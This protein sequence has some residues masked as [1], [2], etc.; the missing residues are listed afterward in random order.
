MKIEQ[1]R[2]FSLDFPA[3]STAVV[4]N[5]SAVKHFGF[6]DP[7]GAKI[8]TFAFEAGAFEAK[9]HA[10]L[11]VIG[12]VKD[13]NFESLKEN[14]TPLCLRLG[15]SNWS[16]P[17]QFQPG[18][19]DQVIMH[20]ER[21]WKAFNPNTPFEYSFL[22]D[23]FGNMYASEKRLGSIFGIFSTLT[24]VIAC[25]GLFAL[26]AFSAEQRT[27]EI[28]VRKVLG[29]S[30]ASIVYLLSREFGKLILIAFV[31][32]APLSWYAVDWWLKDYAYKIEVG[33]F[34]Y[35]SA[36]LFAFLVAGL[37]MSYQSIKAAIVNPVKSLRAE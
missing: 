23:A 30:V 37:T 10:T 5:E 31:I 12:V 28:G 19:T 6:T 25:L 27:K 9:K 29:A 24:I 15:K 1:G 26:T 7:I 3:D 36:G 18:N 21:T 20:L 8:E 2:N 14:I 16:M 22:D 4:I 35:I 33:L 11:T 32:A 34:V 13:F 17:V